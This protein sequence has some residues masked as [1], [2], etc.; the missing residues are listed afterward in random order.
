MGSCFL[1]LCF[2]ALFSCSLTD[3]SHAKYVLAIILK[4]NQCKMDRFYGSWKFV[5]CDNFDDYLKALGIPF[6]LRK[7]AI[8]IS[9]T[10][11]ISK[12]PDGRYS[13]NTDAGIRAVTIV[14]ALGE[15]VP[16]TTVDLR[17]VTSVFT[18]DEEGA[19]VWT[20]TDKYGVTT[21]VKRR[22]LEEDP[23]EMAVHM[24][25]NGVVATAVFTRK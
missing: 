25:V 1:I 8:L 11:T 24:E 23:Q 6:P 10:I 14:F 12:E 19:F 17:N 4:I 13:V 7:M 16:E 9:P 15:S 5:S 3:S 2:V 22:V 18:L 20:S 21:V